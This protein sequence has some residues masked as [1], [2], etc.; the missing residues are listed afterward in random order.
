MG[1]EDQTR[2]ARS[3]LLRS[4]K[5][6]QAQ[7]KF[8]ESTY[9][10][11]PDLILQRHG[12]ALRVR[13]HEGSPNV[14]TLKAPLKALGRASGKATDSGKGKGKAKGR[15][16]NGAGTSDGVV[17]GNA[18]AQGALQH[19]REYE[20]PLPDGKPDLDL[21]ADADLQDFFRREKVDRDLEPVFTTRFERQVIPL[22]F[23]DSRV[24]LALDQ[25]VIAAGERERTL[26]EAELELKGGRAGRL[27]ELAML[28]H[29]QVSFRLEKA[30]KA[31]RGYDLYRNAPPVPQK[32]EKPALSRDM[33]VAQAFETLARACLRQI[34]ANEDAVLDGRDPEGVHQM[35]VGLRRLRA[36]VSAFRG[37]IAPE[38]YAYLREELRWMQQQLGPAR[39]WDVFLDE[40]V[41]PL[42]A[43]LP[44]ADSLGRLAAE[45][46]GLRA[47]GYEQARAGVR[48]DRYTALLLHLE[49][50]LD[51]GGWRRPAE[52]DGSDPTSRPVTGF[53]REILDSRA[54]KVKKLGKRYSA[55]SETELHELRIRGK[56]LRYAGE[57]FH[58]LFPKKATSAYLSRLESIQDVLGAINDAAT[59]QTLLDRLD[60]EIAR[61]ATAPEILAANATGL[62]QGW[63]AA[64]I[65]HQLRDFA[66]TWKAFAKAE[67]FWR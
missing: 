12:I 27:Y 22:V 6:D 39:D 7:R 47:D 3:G 61:G 18:A 24:E 54:R 17:P 44:G 11:T 9:Y 30:S 15:R 40:T 28:L 66:K 20:A 57:F 19:L 10:D 34:R 4:L 45:A 5:T 46:D 26:C 25:G 38:P 8:L 2:L 21:V 60:R 35:R 63:Q 14:Q 67:P 41:A 64:Q 50:W 55:L 58:G 32:A 42:R 52:S 31:A 59:G 48:D 16:G 29:R 65:H 49:L 62:V 13:R 37:V 36:L 1:S 56:K 23:A 53:A 33:T 51:G 43:R